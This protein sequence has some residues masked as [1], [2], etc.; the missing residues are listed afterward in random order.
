M[1]ALLSAHFGDESVIV[2]VQK[3]VEH[4]VLRVKEVVVGRFVVGASKSTSLCAPEA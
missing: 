3:S 4:P 2:E 1:R